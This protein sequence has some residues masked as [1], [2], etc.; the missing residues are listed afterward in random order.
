MLDLHF[1]MHVKCKNNNFNKNIINIF[2]NIKYNKSK[3]NNFF[4][5]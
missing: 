3:P 1:V 4:F 5:E 2:D